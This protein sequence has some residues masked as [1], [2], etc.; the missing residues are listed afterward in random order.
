MYIFR[1]ASSAN[2]LTRVAKLLSGIGDSRIFTFH[3]RSIVQP[4]D[5]AVLLP[6]I[7][8][9]IPDGNK[10]NQSGAIAIFLQAATGPVAMN[11]CHSN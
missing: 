4:P 1:N 7:K 3:A 8:G 9:L 6:L 10:H 5:R 2:K 11:E